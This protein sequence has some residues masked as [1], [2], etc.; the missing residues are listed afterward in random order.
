MNADDYYVQQIQRLEADI[1]F[2]KRDR[3]FWCAEVASDVLKITQLEA[4]LKKAR[5]ELAIMERYAKFEEATI[6]G[7]TLYCDTDAE[8]NI[9][10]V[11]VEPMQDITGLLTP[12]TFNNICGQIED[13]RDQVQQDDADDIRS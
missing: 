5:E 4:D 3:D 9:D 8:G 7:I 2:W 10:G 1:K 12:Q 13:A 11:Y 6:D